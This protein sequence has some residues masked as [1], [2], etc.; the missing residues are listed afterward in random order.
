MEGGG[1][2]PYQA[3]ITINSMV[4]CNLLLVLLR[5]V[6]QITNST[7]GADQALGVSHFVCMSHRQKPAMLHNGCDQCLCCL[8]LFFAAAYLDVDNLPPTLFS[9]STFERTAAGT[10]KQGG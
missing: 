1:I 4:Q 6:M 9:S 10:I 2:Q 8:Y 3:G 5:K 7:Q